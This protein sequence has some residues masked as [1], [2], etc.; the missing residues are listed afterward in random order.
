MYLNFPYVRNSFLLISNKLCDL[1]LLHWPLFRTVIDVGGEKGSAVRKIYFTGPLKL[2]M[3]PLY[4]P[5][6]SPVDLDLA[7]SKSLRSGPYK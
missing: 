3:L 6:K 4:N 1:Y 7:A 2:A 5:L